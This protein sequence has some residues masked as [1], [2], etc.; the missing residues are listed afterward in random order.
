MEVV[1]EVVGGIGEIACRPDAEAVIIATGPLTDEALSLDIIRRLGEDSLSFFDAAAPLVFKNSI[2]FEKAFYA[3]RYGKGDSDY[4]NCPMNEAEYAAFYKEL[5]NAECAEVKDFDSGCVYEGCMPVEVMAGRGFDTLR[6]GPMKP[7][8]I[9]DP[10]TGERFFAVVQLRRDDVSDTLYNIVGFQTRLKF[11]EQKR[12]FGMI[13]GLENAEFARYGV[14]HKNT[15]IKSPG[16]LDQT[17][18]VTGRSAGDDINVPLYFA[19]QITG[20]EGYIESASSG[21]IAGINAY[22]TLKKLP[23]FVTGAGTQTGALAAYV[24][25]YGGADFQPMGANYGIMNPVLPENAGKA[26]IRDK[27][28]KKGLISNSALDILKQTKADRS[29]LF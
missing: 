13:P 20:V 2:N 23:P 10:R 22:C 11:G 24:S 4:I 19:G 5:I 1:S 12:V 17:F 16:V 3:S 6:Y 27:K 29:D 21:L 7:V 18:R 8:G 26:I 14:M 25:N 28:R 15:Y 9:T